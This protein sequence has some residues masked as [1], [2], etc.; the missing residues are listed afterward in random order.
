MESAAYDGVAD[1]APR[2]LIPARYELTRFEPHLTE[3]GF[4]AVCAGALE[5]PGG[6]AIDFTLTLTAPRDAARL[7]MAVAFRPRGEFRNRY[8][9]ELGV[10]QP[11]GLDVRKR[12]IQAGDQGLWWDTRHHYQF[13][14]HVGFLPHPDDNWWHHFYVDQE[15][16]RSYRL[17]RAE[18]EDTAGLEAFRGRR[19]PGWMT[20]YDQGG[21]ALFAYRNPAARAPRAKA[22]KANTTSPNSAAICARTSAIDLAF[23]L[24]Y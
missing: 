15:S 22:G 20:V 16:D 21:G 13:H 3:E 7:E 23:A 18:S 11:L 9:R 17:W 4:S 24:W 1:Y 12:I 19:A 6:D 2:T 14:S 8:I 10:R 5:F